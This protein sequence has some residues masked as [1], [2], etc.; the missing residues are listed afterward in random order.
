LTIVDRLLP[1]GHGADEPTTPT[2]RL[3]IRATPLVPAIHQ[4]RLNS[5][6]CLQHE[7]TGLPPNESAAP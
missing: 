7:R 5:I 6:R 4:G 2:R 1:I 3:T